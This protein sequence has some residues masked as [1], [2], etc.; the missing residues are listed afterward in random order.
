MISTNTHFQWHPG[1]LDR[2]RVDVSRDGGDL[3]LLRPAVGA[4]QVAANARGEEGR[5]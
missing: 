5:H 2:L 1:E 3:F 4:A